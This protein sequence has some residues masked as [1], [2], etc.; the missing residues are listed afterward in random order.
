MASIIRQSFARAVRPRRFFSAATSF[1]GVPPP[2]TSLTDEEVTIRDAAQKFARGVVA[3]RCRAM[4]DAATMHPDV[5]SGL[6]AQGV[7]R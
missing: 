7:R 3:P 1:S 4:D 2:L 5:I 6:F